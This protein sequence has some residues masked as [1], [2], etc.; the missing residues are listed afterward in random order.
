MYLLMYTTT[1]SIAQVKL[2]LCKNKN[3]LIEWKN[4]ADNLKLRAV[5]NATKKQTIESNN[6]F[7][8]KPAIN[9]LMIIKQINKLTTTTI[10][11]KTIIEMFAR[12]I[13]AL[14]WQLKAV[15]TQAVAVGLLKQQR[16]KQQNELKN[17]LG[18]FVK[19]LKLQNQALGKTA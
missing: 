4:S 13:T 7:I 2:A 18:V 12:T 5:N 6:K 14:R 9:E 1:T 11:T 16:Q 8:R 17:H 19:N 15:V 10:K 3:D